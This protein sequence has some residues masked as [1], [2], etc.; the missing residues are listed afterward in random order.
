VPQVR[1]VR[2]ANLGNIDIAGDELGRIDV[3][4]V[5]FFSCKE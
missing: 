1:R 5:Q 4:S 2:R 3:L